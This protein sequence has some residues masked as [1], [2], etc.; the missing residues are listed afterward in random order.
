MQ[1]ELCKHHPIN[2]CCGQKMLGISVYPQSKTFCKTKTKCFLIDVSIRK[3]TTTKGIVCFF[4]MVLL[5]HIGKGLSS[6][7]QMNPP[8]PIPL[9]LPDLLA[10]EI[11]YT[12]KPIQE[13]GG[14]F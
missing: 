9:S 4:L 8:I 6:H 10:W 14:P 11:S 2:I 12:L 1:F 3:K 7:K 5:C 13:H